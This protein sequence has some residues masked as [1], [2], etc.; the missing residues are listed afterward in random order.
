MVQLRKLKLENWLVIVGAFLGSLAMMIP[1]Y[2][3]SHADYSWD[4]NG[5]YVIFGEKYYSLVFFA[6]LYPFPVLL[7]LFFIVI[8]LGSILNNYMKSNLLK[9]FPLVFSA[10]LIVLIFLDY[11][12]V[13]DNSSYRYD[14][15]VDYTIGFYV[16]LIAIISLFIGGF[17]IYFNTK[18]LQ[19]EKLDNNLVSKV[20]DYKNDNET[21][22]IPASCPHCKNPNSKKIRICEWCGNQII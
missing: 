10:I 1:M 6:D 20:S 16:F 8:I 18:N 5:N 4:I 17:L 7:H 21:I 19:S 13:R 14:S 3:C 15:V 2:S 11:F 12:Y 22:I 9:V